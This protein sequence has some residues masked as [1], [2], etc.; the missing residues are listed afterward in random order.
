MSSSR[1]CHQVD[2]VSKY[3]MALNRYIIKV[4]S[5]LP[6]WMIRTGIEAGLSAPVLFDSLIEFNGGQIRFCGRVL[7]P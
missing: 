1:P 4:V 7:P 5:Y 6:V 2:Y 3:S